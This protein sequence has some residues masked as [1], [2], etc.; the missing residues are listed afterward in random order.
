[1]YLRSDAAGD[2]ADA[3]ESLFDRIGGESAVDAAVDLFYQKIL[4]DPGLSRF[5]ENVNLSRLRKKQK[6]FLTQSFGGPDRFKGRDLTAAHAGSV[7]IGLGDQH[8][9]VVAGHLRA[10]LEEWGE[11]GKTSPT[12][13]WRSSNPCGKRSLAA[14]PQNPS[15]RR[16]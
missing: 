6:A 10:T 5:F 9:D 16:V 15:S 13:S 4:A 8:F 14:R 7:T 1:M 12:K 11:Q 2:S 3:S